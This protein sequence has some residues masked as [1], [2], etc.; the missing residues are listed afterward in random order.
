MRGITGIIVKSVDSATKE[1][2][3]Q[4]EALYKI[5]VTMIEVLPPNYTPEPFNCIITA[6]FSET[7]TLEYV[8]HQ[9]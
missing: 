9:C 1:T 2:N 4:N 5:N 3:N 8:K 6:L 7:E